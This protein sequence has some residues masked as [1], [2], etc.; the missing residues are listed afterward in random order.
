[1]MLAPTVMPLQV[2][3][4]ARSTSGWM[5]PF[6]VTTILL[7]EVPAPQALND[8]GYLLIREIVVEDVESLELLWGLAWNDHPASA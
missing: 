3:A 5:H 2:G 8:H 4:E 7:A 1:M 6:T